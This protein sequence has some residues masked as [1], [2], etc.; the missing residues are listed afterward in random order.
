MNRLRKI[1]LLLSYDHRTVLLFAE[2]FLFLGWAR[3][4]LVFPFAKIAPSL[5]SKTAE[6]SNE[7][8]PQEVRI[9]KSISSAVNIVSRHTVWD[10]KC[11]V[12][13]IA[14]MKMLQR[15]HIGSTLYLG[16]ARDGS[17]RLIAHAWLRSGPLY[18]TG[19]DVMRK[20]AVVETFAQSA[21]MPR[22]NAQ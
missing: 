20:F 9:I 2:A 8:Q 15:R 14:G 13:A 1:R 3:M 10:S 18:I 6:T 7:L 19:D 22:R 12:R 21:G 16:T 11:L 4:L 5:G 17:G